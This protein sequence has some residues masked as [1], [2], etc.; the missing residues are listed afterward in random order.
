VWMSRISFSFSVIF[1][2]LDVECVKPPNPP[3]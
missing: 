2:A 1:L 3:P